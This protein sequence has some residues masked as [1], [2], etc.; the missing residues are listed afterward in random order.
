MITSMWPVAIARHKGCARKWSAVA[1]SAATVLLGSAP[2]YAAGPRQPAGAGTEV[3]HANAVGLAG[4][5]S[6]TE[7]KRTIKLFAAC[8]AAAKALNTGAEAGTSHVAYSTSFTD[9]EVRHLGENAWVAQSLARTKYDAD[10]SS[11][12][13][14]VP[15][16]KGM[17]DAENVAVKS[18]EEALLGHEN[19]HLRDAEDFFKHFKP[20]ALT[21]AGESRSAALK[22]LRNQQAESKKA[23]VNI[24]Q[25]RKN[26]YDTNTDNGRAQP[27][28]KNAILTCPR[29]RAGSR[30]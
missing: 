9:P 5:G 6:L 19:G 21:G 3:G 30:E 12:T 1:V 8:E 18:F 27:G 22:D 4:K 28:G 10:K 20:G 29:S 15:T 14:T 23:V 2:A 17:T 7:I 13:L 26:N 11:I 25:A 16:W 24:L